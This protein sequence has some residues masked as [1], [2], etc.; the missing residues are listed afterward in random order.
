MDDPAGQIRNFGFKLNG[1]FAK[2]KIWRHAPTKTL[3]PFI[4]VQPISFRSNPRELQELFSKFLVV[5]LSEEGDFYEAFNH[6]C[7]GCSDSYTRAG[8]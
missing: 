6:D 7:R 1:N 2:Q 3:K 8:R 5:S 4:P